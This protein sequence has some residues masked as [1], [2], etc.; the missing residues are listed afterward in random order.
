MPNW[1]HCCAII[2]PARV[3]TGRPSPST[4]ILIVNG[5][6]SGVIHWLPTFLKPAFSSSSVAAC[7]SGFHQPMPKA[8]AMSSAFS[9]IWMPRLGRSE[10]AICLP[11]VGVVRLDLALAGIDLEGLEPGLDRPVVVV[12]MRAGGRHADGRDRGRAA[13]R[14]HRHRLDVDQQRQRPA[15]VA[16]L[17]QLVLVVEDHRRP[18]SGRGG[19]RESRLNQP[20]DS[21]D[22]LASVNMPS[23]EMSWMMSS[24]WFICA[25][26]RLSGGPAST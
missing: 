20:R 18:A 17:Q 16:V 8:L 13:V 2:E 12:G 22:C 6:P 19:R 11:M 25:I 14:G 23:G 10:S 7:G 3:I 26:T 15:H 9:G 5:L 21:R 1:R 4:V 24:W